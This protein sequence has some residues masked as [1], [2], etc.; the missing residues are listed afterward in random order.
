MGKPRKYSIYDLEPGMKVTGIIRRVWTKV[1]IVDIGADRLGRLHVRDYRRDIT[2]YGF[3]KLGRTHKYAYTAYSL[4][5]Q[6][7]L[8]V[9][10]VWNDDHFTLT[11]NKP[12]SNKPTA[13]TPQRNTI[14]GLQ[15]HPDKPERITKEQL[16]DREKAEA[17]KKPWDPYVAHVDEWLEDAMEPDEAAD[18][19]VARTEKD[20]F[21]EMNPDYDE[22]EDEEEDTFDAQE[23]FLNELSSD[24]DVADEDF[25]ADDFAE[26]DFGTA[27]TDASEVGFGPHAFPAKELDGWVLDETDDSKLDDPNK[28]KVESGL[29]EAELE[30]MFS[31][32]DDE[33]E[34]EFMDE[35]GDT[36]GTGEGGFPSKTPG[37][38]T[39]ASRNR[40]I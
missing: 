40:R 33:N 34:D 12:R 26:D 21:E 14:P 25:A 19:W 5:A 20:L 31:E 11:C 16:R 28:D 36:Y 37:I 9:H 3:A 8:W 29:T 23:Q 7:D 22:D 35:F 18:S 6:V 1:A 2:R 32:G 27:A 4:G 30:D 24:P 10:R 17:E 15:M 38:W 39:A 13:D